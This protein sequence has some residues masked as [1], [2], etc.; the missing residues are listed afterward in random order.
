MNEQLM[1]IKLSG[2]WINFFCLPHTLTA[3]SYKQPIMLRV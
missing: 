3:A 2:D 1:D